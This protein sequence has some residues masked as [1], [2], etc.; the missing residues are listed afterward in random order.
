MEPTDLFELGRER[1]VGKRV[2]FF[3][4]AKV[5]KLKVIRKIRRYELLLFSDVNLILLHPRSE[6]QLIV[7]TFNTSWDCRYPIFCAKFSN[8]DN[9]V[10]HSG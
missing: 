6:Y 2:T 3:L 7:R 10:G 5:A 4:G 8:F 9:L 1:A